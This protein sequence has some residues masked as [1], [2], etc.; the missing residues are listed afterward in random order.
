MAHPDA[1]AYPGTVFDGRWEVGEYLGDGHFSIVFKGLDV[2]DGSDCAI[3]VLSVTRNTAENLLE[4]ERDGALLRKLRESSNIVDLFGAGKYQMEVQTAQTGLS[5][6]LEVSYLVL[7]RADGDLAQ[8]LVDRKAITWEDRLALFRDIT[9]GIHQMHLQ[10]L[11]HRDLKGDNVLVM[12]EKGQAVAKV[13]DLGRGRDTKDSSSFPSFVY[14][15]GRGDLRFAPPEH[16]WGLGSDD[17]EAMRHGDLYL[18]GSVLFEIATGQGLSG[19]VVGD[20]LRIAE[21]KRELSETVRRTDFASVRRALQRDHEI[22]YALFRDELPTAMRTDAVSLL[23]QLTSVDPTQ[24]EPHHVTR[25][26]SVW[27]L[28]WI[29]R[30]IDRIGLQLRIEKRRT[31]LPWK[32]KGARKP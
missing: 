26:P 22:A 8:L 15:M 18:L 25:R 6:P 13:T 3:K 32:Q 28:Q 31:R 9:K 23:R 20:P 27:D 14:E 21:A 17:P 19:L 4:F 16:L 30:R 10:Y 24:R 29:L 5:I 11:V 1:T 12:R 2:R 7:E